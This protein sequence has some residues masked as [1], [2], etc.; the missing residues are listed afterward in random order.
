MPAAKACLAI[1]I[2][3]APPLDYL[4]G[5]VNG[6]ASIARWAEQAGYRTTL[7]VDAETPVDID[8]VNAALTGLLM[9]RGKTERLLIYFA[10]HGLARDAAE[11]L[12]LLSEWF[13][14]Q[15]A[16][17]VGGLK[18]RLERFGIEQIAIVAD[19]CRSLPNDLDTA[20]LTPDNVLGRG[21]VDPNLPLVDILKASS[22][23]RAA[24]MISGPTAEDDRC[25]FT[26]VLEEALWGAKAGAFADDRPGVI[27]SGS[28]AKY[29]RAEVPVRAREYEVELRPDIVSG[30]LSPDDVYV[31]APAP[32]A[33][34]LPSW[35]PA[36]PPGAMGPDARGAG[37][38]RRGWSTAGQPEASGDD[39]LEWLGD[40]GGDL[41]RQPASLE[42]ESPGPKVTA[43]DD[44]K[45]IEEGRADRQKRKDSFAA[46]Y[47]GED[48][49]T[50]YETAAGFAISGASARRGVLGKA[51]IAQDDRDGRWWRVAP[52]DPP[53]MAWSGG[54][55]HEP[56]PLLVELD[57]GRW[58]GAAALPQFVA[59]FSIDATGAASLIY[60]S[61]YDTYGIEMTE[62]AVAA[63]RAGAMAA[64][65]A[66]AF[67]V[68][69]RQRKHADP[70]MGV[71]A[72]YLYDSQGDVESIRQIASFYAGAGQAIPYDIAVLGRLKTSAGPEGQI[73]AHVPAVA[74]RAPQGPAEEQ[75]RWTYDATPEAGGLVG[76]AF[77]WLRQ[78]WSL[79]D[80]EVGSAL[81]PE[82]LLEV[83]PH[84]LPSPFTAFDAEGGKLLCGRIFGS[85]T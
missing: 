15:R 75:R 10:G 74:A 64:Q 16:V 43:E 61:M 53:G 4:P 81:V 55:L 29:L 7:L 19:A 40:D 23:F 6:A 46:A 44:R 63:L 68:E 12:W 52:P 85:G 37:G 57:D 41:P 30:F 45:L 70:V 34:A 11:D 69:L 3:D 56:L 17:A 47:A 14:D 27:T 22:K 24:Y 50:H 65:D 60:R 9:G 1:G 58:V 67:A 26:G 20:D 51:A 79:L 82:G 2:S 32:P 78:G 76:G 62:R 54:R 35:P 80:D 13:S 49:P 33:P 38:G 59:T 42:P 18:R 72:A 31:G 5:A 77:P 73:V 36:G 83:L 48:R 71:L 66:R 8:S 25:I 39:V 84:L 21:P 28:L